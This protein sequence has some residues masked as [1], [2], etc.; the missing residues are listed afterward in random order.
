MA[1]L[2][3]TTTLNFINANV[4]E[5]SPELAAFKP[6]FNAG[7]EFP[8]WLRDISGIPMAYAIF[9]FPSEGYPD[10]GAFLEAFPDL[11]KFINLANDVISFWKEEKAGETRNYISLRAQAEGKPAL[12]VMQAVAEETVACADRVEAILSKEGREPYYQVWRSFLD[13]YMS[14]HLTSRRYK[15][16]VLGLERQSPL[17]RI[18]ES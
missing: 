16:D 8:Y 14:F 4:I 15:L 5:S 9:M 6:T 12:E 11:N 10:V 7:R 17:P 13:G 3:V 2:L 1:N 18:F